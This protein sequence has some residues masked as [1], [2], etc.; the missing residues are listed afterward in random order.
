M[1]ETEHIS[2]DSPNE[3]KGVDFQPSLTHEQIIFYLYTSCFLSFFLF[4]LKYNFF[5]YHVRNAS[6]KVLG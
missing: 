5:V 1:F 4:N 6:L 3:T 2:K